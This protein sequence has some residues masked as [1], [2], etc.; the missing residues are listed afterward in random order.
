ML[1]ISCCNNLFLPFVQQL[2]EVLAKQAE[3]GVE[4][5]EIPPSYLSELE[6]HPKKEKEGKALYLTDRFPNKYNNK[7][8][9][10]G[11]DQWNAKRP[12]L[13]NEASTDSS[14]TVKKRDSTLLQKLL[15]A[16][17]KRD[18]IQLLQVFRFMTRNSFFNGLPDKPLE[19]PKII[20]KDAGLENEL[21]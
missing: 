12:K 15:N 2:K 3:L 8:G 18:K 14:P 11:R 21:T 7:R 10:H 5:A 16:E 17:I 13:K 6:N 4:V 1:A 9:S 19:F 20:V